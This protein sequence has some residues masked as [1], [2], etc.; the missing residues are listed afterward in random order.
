M[1]G[2]D[3]RIRMEQFVKTQHG[4]K[5]Q[6]DDLE[7]AWTE[8]LREFT[9]DVKNVVDV[10]REKGHTDLYVDVGFNQLHVWF[11]TRPMG[12][13]R[14]AERSRSF[15]AEAGAEAIFVC[16]EGLVRGY[17]RPFRPEGQSA[18]FDPFVELGSPQ[19]VERNALANAVGDFLQWA[20]IGGGRGSRP[21]AL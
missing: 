12:R 9:P 14:F 1:S 7:R 20:A 10:L 3:P 8:K 4:A 21:L 16:Q 6:E 15:D 17:R 11:G 13:P 5:R 18:P 2:D 19:G